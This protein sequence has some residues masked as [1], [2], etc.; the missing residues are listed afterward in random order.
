MDLRTGSWLVLSLNVRYLIHIHYLLTLRQATLTLCQQA[1]Q[2]LSG[3]EGLR[4]ETAHCVQ[5]GLSHI[6]I[7]IG[8]EQDTHYNS[9]ALI[10]G[11]FIWANGSPLATLP[12]H[13]TRW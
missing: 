9:R 6:K 4:N 13:F 2:I 3:A 5:L 1:F 7:I 12:G 8:N 11:D 10:T